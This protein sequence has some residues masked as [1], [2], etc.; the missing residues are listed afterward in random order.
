[1]KATYYSRRYDALRQQVDRYLT[2]AVEHGGPRQL[3]DACRYVLAGGGK[4]LRA[5]LTLLSCEAVGGRLRDALH[6]SA[7]VEIMHNFTLVHD[8]VMDHAPS[9]RGRP[10]VHIRWDLNSAL[11]VGDVLLGLSY[12]HLLRTKS[13]SL[14]PLVS[15]FTTCVI[16]VCEGQALDLEFED[17]TDVTVQAYFRMIGKKTG[18][19]ISLATELGARIGGGS[20]RQI[21]A[22]ARFGLYL[23]RA[24][25]LRDDLLDVVADRK[26]FGKAI[27]GDIMEGKK[28]FLLLTAAGRARGN[29]RALIQRVLRRQAHTLG[30]SRKV[31][32]T[33]TDIYRRYGVIADAQKLI[34]RNTGYAT[35]ALSSLP[36]TR[37][38][39]MLSWLADELA[40][41]AA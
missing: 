1:M 8:D 35:K 37:T 13:A 34:G 25:Q 16:E 28:T 23:G 7:A 29:D 31:V 19:L 4:R 11:L 38:T 24:F 6:A 14:P 12:R 40:Q 2:A 22:L 5:V 33:V 36:T 21:A 20:P 3:T 41:R 15:S 39:A 30:P 32:P 10:T 27:G 9:R 18:R 17:R 26:E